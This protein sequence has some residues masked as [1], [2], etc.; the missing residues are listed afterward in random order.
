MECLYFL[1]YGQCIEQIKSSIV[2]NNRIFHYEPVASN[3]VVFSINNADS[4]ILDFDN[5]PSILSFA[6]PNK[7]SE[8][9]YAGLFIISTNGIETSRLV[10]HIHMELSLMEHLRI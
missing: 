6:L 1:G 3:E 9:L 7:I 2:Y 10:K 5:F 8:Y 4:G